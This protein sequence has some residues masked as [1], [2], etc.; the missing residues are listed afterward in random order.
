MG[1]A[2]VLN[3]PTLI[4]SSSASTV[5]R[6]LGNLDDA[7]SISLFMASTANANSSAAVIQVSQFDPGFPTPAGVTQSTAWYNLSTA[8]ATVTSS[9]SQVFINAVCFRGLRLS[10]TTSNA[11]EIIAYVSKEVRV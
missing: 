5:T 6:A 10:V 3:L 7:V 11:G 8:V 4:P 2:T 9:A 1:Y